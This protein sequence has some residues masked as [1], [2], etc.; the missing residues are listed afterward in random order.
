MDA[1]LADGSV[2][3]G[4]GGD[5]VATASYIV[6]P[7]GPLSWLDPGAF[8]TLGVGAGFALAAKLVRPES[9]VWLLWGDGSAGYGLAE[10]DTFVR[11]GLGVL[12]L[13]GN[14]ASWA[15]IARDQVPMLGDD[16]GTTL[17]RSDYHRAAEGLGAAGVVVPKSAD[18][19][20]VLKG[21]LAE[22]RK[23]TPVVVNAHLARTD[24]R[25]ESI[26]M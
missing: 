24:F 17:R 9:D 16:V 22:T 3:I 8:G 18:A 1:S 5:F 7:R 4:D 21:A 20:A 10:I 6:S 23:G 13:I 15:Q 2:L 11:H 25:K 12:A 19:A 14:D 26:S